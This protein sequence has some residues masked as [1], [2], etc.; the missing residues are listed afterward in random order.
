MQSQV[1]KDRPPYIA[2]VGGPD[3]SLR[4]PLLKL[5]NEKG[6]KVAAVSSNIKEKSLFEQ[7]GISCFL[8]HL[9]RK[10]GFLIEIKS[11]FTLYNILRKEKFDIVHAFDT[12]PTV[13]AR[14]TAK[15]TQ[16]PIIIGT[17]PGLGSLFSEVNILN[18]IMGRIYVIA[19]K[20]GCKVSDMTIFQNKDDRDF[21][22]ENKI[23][24]RSKVA[25]IKGSGVDTKKFSPENVI[26]KT[27]QKIKVELC[28]NSGPVISMIT[29]LVNYKGIK[30]YLEAASLL[31]AKYPDVNFLLI[32]PQDK[33]LATFPLEEIS[34]YSKVVKYLGHRSD[35]PEILFFSDIVVL[36]SYYR[37][38]IPRVLLEAASMGK[39]IVTTNLP[40]CKEIVEDG[41]NGFLIP[42][43]NAKSLAE[44]IEKLILNEDLRREMGILSRKK[45]V[46]E[47]DSDIVF[48][49]TLH[50]YADLL[51]NKLGAVL[52][53]E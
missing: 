39:P 34:R 45:V 17:I 13:I 52:E 38:G 5:L 33:T 24:N 12:K 53:H 1:C 48:R 42:P 21:F 3:I 19:Q 31:K 43:Q 2:Y 46:E 4:I 23:T 29:R 16:T 9:E 47:F 37:E 50:L 30:E 18:K 41:K 51:K 22:I 26:P 15:L 28:L 25:I 49:E 44:A 14:I 35:I 7:E 6:F 36:P 20:I 8:Y 10:L 11:F 40:G 32:G 27:V